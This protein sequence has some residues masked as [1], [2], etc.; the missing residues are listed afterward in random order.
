MGILGALA[1]ADPTIKKC[2]WCGKEY[3]REKSNAISTGRFCSNK[4]ETEWEDHEDKL[5]NEYEESVNRKKQKTK[6]VIKEVIKEKIVYKYL[7]F[8]G[9]TAWA[10][11]VS[12]SYLLKHEQYK[13]AIDSIFLLDNII[14]EV[15]INLDNEEIPDH[16][17]S[18]FSSTGNLMDDNSDLEQ[19]IIDLI[20][21]LF[22]QRELSGLIAK[23]KVLVVV[24]ELYESI[25]YYD[26]VKVET[27]SR[28]KIEPGS[29]DYFDYIHSIQEKKNILY[30]KFGVKEASVE[31]YKKLDN[32]LIDATK[33]LIEAK[34]SVGNSKGIHDILKKYNYS[35]SHINNIIDQLILID[36]IPEP[37][38]ILID[39]QEDM[40]MDEDM[41]MGIVE[42][43]IFKWLIGLNEYD[44]LFE[45]AA[46]LVV[47]N[48]RANV[49]LIQH[50]LAIGL[51][52]ATR[53]VDQLEHTG[54]I[55]QVNEKNERKVLIKDIQELR[56]FL[57]SDL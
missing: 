52:R 13:L 39:Y 7:G 51:N 9:F 32:S 34:Y 38:E 48:Q 21:L 56:Y 50:K 27:T 19:T 31:K 15:F 40:T 3:R 6:T 2:E 26:S 45:D 46:E 41:T 20:S 12:G 16:Y 36:I 37:H 17:K 49:Q 14:E 24:E 54:I 23:L 53:L 4:C 44:E 11:F 25:K 42:N 30:K 33:L 8:D 43:K 57:V 47:T 18:L 29:D 35:N 55:S 22:D 5:Y 1:G 10:A 28:Q